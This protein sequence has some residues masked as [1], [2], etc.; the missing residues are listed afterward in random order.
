ML[1]M[2]CNPLIKKVI[3]EIQNRQGMPWNN[4]GMSNDKFPA[5]EEFFK[6]INSGIP[7][8]DYFYSGD[9]FRLHTPYTTFDKWIHPEEGE[10][11]GVAS[12]DHSC[13]FLPKTIY[14]GRV[15]AFSKNCDF[16]NRAI[17][18]KVHSNE[19]ARL[20]HIN[21]KDLYGIDVNKFMDLFGHKLEL[22]EKEEEVLFPLNKEYVVKEYKGTPNKFKYYLRGFQKEVRK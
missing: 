21:T 10:I 9:L 7:K 2:C 13:R 16:T 20:I 12:L 22:Y 17:F 1:I 6:Y 8:E 5:I 18:P 14:N 19:T 3:E 4:G 15:V 11:L